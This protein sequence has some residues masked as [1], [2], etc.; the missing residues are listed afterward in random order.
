[1]GEQDKFTTTIYWKP[2]FNGVYS[3]FERFLPSVY[4]FGMVYTLVYRCFCICSNYTQFHTELIFLKGMFQKN[5]YPE[6]F[7]DKCF[8]TLLNNIYLVKESVPTVEKSVYS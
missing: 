2:T 6:N 8:K 4:N 1:M 7:I 3:S 5:D